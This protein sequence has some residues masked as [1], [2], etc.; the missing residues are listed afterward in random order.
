MDCDVI[1]SCEEAIQLLINNKLL[2]E[3]WFIHFDDWGIKT[4]IP[5]W[6]E[7]FSTTI[8]YEYNIVSLYQTNLTKSFILER[9]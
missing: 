6:F 4:G 7:N 2:N 1:K 9:K 3:I 8:L 5:E